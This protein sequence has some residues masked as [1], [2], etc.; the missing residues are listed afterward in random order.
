MSRLRPECRSYTGPRKALP[1]DT[2]LFLVR[3]AVAASRGLIT[4]ALDKGQEHCAIGAFWARN[5]GEILPGG[6]VD[7]VAAVNDG[8]VGTP[9]ARKRK[10]LQWLNMKLRQIGM[11]LRGPKPKG[12]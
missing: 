7:E 10:M 11:P 9:A 5:H 2:A 8:I 12:A 6:F 4:G 1:R 3:E